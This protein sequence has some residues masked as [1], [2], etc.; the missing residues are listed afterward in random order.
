MVVVR[1][2][3]IQEMLPIVVIGEVLDKM[4]SGMTA[5][6]VMAYVRKWSAQKAQMQ[7]AADAGTF[8]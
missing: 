7:A 6:G 2:R 8:H 4:D 5:A 3:K 1:L